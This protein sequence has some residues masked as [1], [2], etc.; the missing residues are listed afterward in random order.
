M[1]PQLDSAGQTYD[2]GKDLVRLT[3]Q[4]LRVFAIMSDGQWRTLRTIQDHVGGSEAGVSA[5]L[6]DLRKDKF[7]GH[8][9][10]RKRLVDGLF[11]YRLVIRNRVA[12]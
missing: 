2:R 11:V 4:L 9:V 1:Q 6:R 12:G 7:G 10:E 5:R 3:G 8:N